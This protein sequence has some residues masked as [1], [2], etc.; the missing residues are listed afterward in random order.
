MTSADKLSPADQKW[1]D[2][3]NALNADYQ[4]KQDAAFLDKLRAAGAR[5]TDCVHNYTAFDSCPVCD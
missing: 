3:I 2:D 5:T 4:A 1:I